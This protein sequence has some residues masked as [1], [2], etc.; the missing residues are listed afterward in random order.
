MIGLGYAQ[1]STSNLNVSA[2]VPAS[3]QIISVGD[4]NFGSYDPLN[5]TPT[6]AVGNITF[7]CVKGTSYTSF[8]V[9]AREMTGNGDTLSFQLYSDSARSQIFADDNSCEGDTSSSINPI[10][11]GIYGRIEPGQ[12]VSAANYSTTLIATVEY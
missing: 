11:Q 4:I 3:C 7:R 12:D 8:I 5:A 10:V 1:T 9:G 2:T 6:D